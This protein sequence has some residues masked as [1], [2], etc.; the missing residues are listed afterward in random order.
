[1][2][3]SAR[4]EALRELGGLSWITCLRAP[5][6]AKL[7]AEDGP[8]QLSLFDQQDLAEIT[9]PDYPGERL[10]ACRNPYLATERARKREALLA[11]TEALLAPITA[12]VAEGR[13]AG[14]DR[15]GLRAGKVINRYKMAKHFDVTITDTSLAITR[16]ADQ[17]TAEAALDGIYVLRTPLPAS[18]L[19]APATVAAYKNLS[20]VEDDFRSLKTIDVDLRPIHHYLSE[21]VRAHALICMLAAYLI[22]HLRAAL[23]PLTYTDEH[24]PTRDNPV[25]PAV[26]STHAQ[27]K[28]AQHTDDTGAP[29]HSFRGLLEHMATLTRNTITLGNTTFDKI[30]LPTPT[31]R[32]AF[33]L[34]NAPIP[35]TLK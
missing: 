18:Q 4:I 20:H 34:I 21:R 33:E 32:R 8:L 5:A 10:I 2:I 22:W 15:I 35:L 29:L 6:I 1:M 31:Q 17:I 3:T 26:R 14:A 25:T 28:I 12:A 30:T 27:H 24:P 7:A 11:A 23:T 19:D 16:R 9:H 13:L